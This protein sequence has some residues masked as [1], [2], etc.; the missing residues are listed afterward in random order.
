MRYVC[1][2]RREP[3]YALSLIFAMLTAAGCVYPKLN[4]PATDSGG[5]TGGGSCR[6]VATLDASVES[7]Y[8]SYPNWN[9]YVRASDG[10]TACAG[11]EQGIHSKCYNGGERRKVTLT[12]HSSCDGLTL[13]ETLGAFQWKCEVASGTA[14]FIS[15]GLKP[16]ISLKDLIDNSGASPVWKPNSVT[17]TKGSCPVTATTATAWWTNPISRLSSNVGAG[18][19][20]LSTDG[21]VYIYSGSL[22]TDGY[23]I[24]ANKISLVGLDSAVLGFSG[25]GTAAGNMIVANTRNFIWIEGTY[26]GYNAAGSAQAGVVINIATVKF[27]RFKNLNIRGGSSSCLYTASTVS[28]LFQN[29]NFA[30]SAN[31]LF[32]TGSSNYNVLQ[33]YK[34]FGNNGANDIWLS[35][36]F[37]GYYTNLLVAN[38]TV[39]I[40]LADASYYST[41]SH[42]TAV[43]NTT[44]MYFLQFPSYTTWTNSLFANNDTGF[45]SNHMGS[46]TSNLKF[47]NI[48]VVNNTTGISLDQL[49]NST[50]SHNLLVGGNGTDCTVS[51]GTNPGL[52]NTTCANQGSSSATLITG[53][54][55]ANSFKGKVTTTDATNGANTNGVQA[56]ASMSEWLKFASPFRVW[57]IDG[58]AFPNS[59]NRTACAAGNCRIWDFALKASDTQF[60]DRTEDGQNANDPFVDGASCPS[61][62]D[63]NVTITNGMTPANT[64]LLNALEILGSG[65]NDNGLCESN[66]SCVYTPNFGA[67]QGSGDYTAHTCTFH[68]GTVSGV[69]MYAYPVNG[70]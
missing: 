34:G 64:Y 29:L 33:G 38:N 7:R 70:E 61:A 26:N 13:T 30:Q 11:T 43:N 12:G 47:A 3:Y 59:D 32:F 57:G 14:R 6:D 66:E 10:T 24:G 9:D 18:A 60:R 53:K 4:A 45:S 27:S 65:G 23:V 56:F 19:T 63:G 67:Y 69:T 46:N 58:S 2:R 52:V 41:V 17:V 28:N 16:S 31:A 42:V 1:G 40:K 51:G 49:N 50:F 44:G 22:L 68:D 55:A 54:T 21:T 37:Y 8:A 15:T 5:T 62:V 39:G 20:T 25:S 48:A 35:V 36:A